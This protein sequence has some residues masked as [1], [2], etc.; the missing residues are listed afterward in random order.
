MTQIK[1]GMNARSILLRIS[2][3]CFKLRGEKKTGLIFFVDNKYC[4]IRQ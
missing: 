3:W 2:A 4:G 1:N